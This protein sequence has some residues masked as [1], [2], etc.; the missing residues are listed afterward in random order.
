MEMMTEGVAQREKEVRS[1]TLT[2]LKRVQEREERVERSFD[3]PKQ[4]VN[5]DGHG[6]NMSWLALSLANRLCLATN[7]ST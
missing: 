7:C 2:G 4:I 5:A 3:S 1:C 6:V